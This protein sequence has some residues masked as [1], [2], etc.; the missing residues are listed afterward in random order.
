LFGKDYRGSCQVAPAI[1]HH[2]SHSVQQVILFQNCFY[3]WSNF[4]ACGAVLARYD[5]DVLVVPL[6]LFVDEVDVDREVI[7]SFPGHPQV[8]GNG[9]TSNTNEHT[10]NMFATLSFQSGQQSVCKFCPRRQWQCSIQKPDE[11][12]EERVLHNGE[13]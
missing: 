4:L 5:A 9:N 12:F 3:A 11:G 1:L 10:L 8:K 13:R 6:P 2:S 7:L